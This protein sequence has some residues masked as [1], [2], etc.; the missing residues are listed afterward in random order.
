MDR[1]FVDRLKKK[2]DDFYLMK[3]QHFLNAKEYG[4][5]RENQGFIKAIKIIGE[6]IDKNE[7]EAK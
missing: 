4:D 3:Y 5:L 6:F 2:I 1:E 7:G